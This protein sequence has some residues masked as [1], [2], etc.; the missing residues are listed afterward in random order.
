MTNQRV[1][2]QKT[3][4]FWKHAHALSLYCSNDT[5]LLNPLFHCFPKPCICSKSLGN[6][7]GL[8]FLRIILSCTSFLC[9]FLTKTESWYRKYYYLNT[10]STADYK[11]F[12]TQS[13]GF[14][15][16]ERGLQKHNLTRAKATK[17]PPKTWQPPQ[18]KKPTAAKLHPHEVATVLRKKMRTTMD[19]T[20]WLK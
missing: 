11:Y 3:C 9:P 1:F 16:L 19:L 8:R 2:W 10:N 20:C 6:I 4:R 12:P 7:I 14:S 17:A 13:W 18:H 5:A 15:F